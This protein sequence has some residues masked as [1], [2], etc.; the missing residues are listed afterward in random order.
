[1]KAVYVKNLPVLFKDFFE[2]NRTGKCQYIASESK[3]PMN[4]I[5]SHSEARVIKTLFH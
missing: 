4:L 3:Y 1:M 2:E 5:I